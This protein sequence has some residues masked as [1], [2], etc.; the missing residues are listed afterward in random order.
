MERRATSFVGLAK[1]TQ[2]AMSV[3]GITSAPS[4]A[5]NQDEVEQGPTKAKRKRCYKCSLDRKSS[6]VCTSCT[7]TVCAYHSTKSVEIKCRNLMLQNKFFS[8]KRLC[9]DAKT[10][11][12]R[13]PIS[14][15]NVY[16]TLYA[17]EG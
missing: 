13:G 12:S 16:K 8:F 1:P 14:C 15:K 17:F 9:L 4:V 3:R 11:G 7:R 10:I 2:Q 5:Y 6:W